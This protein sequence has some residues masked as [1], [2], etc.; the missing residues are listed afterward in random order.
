[1]PG[2][3]GRE[4][5]ESGQGW[6]WE[7]D[8]G[9]MKGSGAGWEVGGDPTAGQWRRWGLRARSHLIEADGS[10]G[11]ATLSACD[12][13]LRN[14]RAASNR[15]SSSHQIITLKTHSS[16]ISSHI[17]H[18]TDHHTSGHH[19]MRASWQRR[20]MHARP[21][22]K[23]PQRPWPH[24]MGRFAAAGQLGGAGGELASQGLSHAAADAPTGFEP[25][26]S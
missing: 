1:M 5:G 13:V 15:L 12:A 16:G 26:S 22:T 8:G 24:A 18:H 14:K 11:L 9:G 20:S 7:R 4:R 10:E 25:C 2:R 21:T 6:G 23:Q 19:S 17:T 3:I